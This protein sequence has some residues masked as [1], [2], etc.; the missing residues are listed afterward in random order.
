MWVGRARREATVETSVLSGIRALKKMSVAE[1]K[2][3]WE[4]V[5]GAPPPSQNRHHLWKRLAWETQARAHGGLSPDARA[6][7]DE[8]GQEAFDR[9]TS[10][11]QRAHGAEPPASPPKV[12]RIRDQRRL[13]AGTVLTRVYHGQEIRVVALDDG[14]FEYDGQVYSSLSAVARAVTGQKWNGRLFFGLTKRKR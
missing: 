4:R 5:F 13:A 11:R 9:A 6:R 3:E 12:T 2:Q 1:L 7:L 8:L 14:Q 10:R